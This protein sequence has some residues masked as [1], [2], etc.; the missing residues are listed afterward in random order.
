M[1]KRENETECLQIGHGDSG[2]PLVCP[3]LGGSFVLWGVVSFSGDCTDD[4]FSPGV[5]HLVASSREWIFNT[6]AKFESM[7]VVKDSKGKEFGKEDNKKESK[8]EVMEENEKEGKEQI[9]KE[10]RRGS[11]EHPKTKGLSEREKERRRKGKEKW[12]KMMRER[13]RKRRERENGRKGRKR[14]GEEEKEVGTVG[15][16]KG[17]KNRRRN[18]N[19][20]N[21]QRRIGRRENGSRNGKESEDYRNNEFGSPILKQISSSHDYE[22]WDHSGR[23]SS[24]IDFTQKLEIEEMEESK[25]R[26]L[27]KELVKQ[28]WLYGRRGWE[29]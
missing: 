24:T 27:I 28:A 10:K 23:H 19:K 20:P 16:R 17:R 3:N 6:I 1:T 12:L 2:G 7:K 21:R 8:N 22:D 26:K 18:G 5:F 13:Q 25:L 15:G 11:R 29:I 14:K 4:R 9:K